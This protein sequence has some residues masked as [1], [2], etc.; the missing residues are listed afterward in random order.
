M[1]IIVEGCHG[2]WKKYNIDYS[3]DVYLQQTTFKNNISIAY[4]L[5]DYLIL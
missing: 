1:F 2:Y 3:N 5:I 4:V